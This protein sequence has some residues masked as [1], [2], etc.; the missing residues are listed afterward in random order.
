MIYNVLYK[1]FS[2]GMAFK[3]DEALSWCNTKDHK[4]EVRKF[5]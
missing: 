2:V 5:K 3:K 4:I 1:G